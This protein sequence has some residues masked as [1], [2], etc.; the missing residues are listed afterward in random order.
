MRPRTHPNQVRVRRV[1]RAGAASSRPSGGQVGLRLRRSA[2][3][4]APL[5][6]A[7]A[8]VALSLLA[9]GCAEGFGVGLPA[10]E[11]VIRR[12][13]T[14]TILTAQ[15]VP[16]ARL[17]PCIE[18]LKLGWDD[19]T[20]GARDGLTELTF[21]HAN[22]TFLTVRLR[23]SCG[24]DPASE[25]PSG[26][27]GVTRYE[28]VESVGAEIA[29][30][31]IPSSELALIYARSLVDENPNLEING[32]LVVFSVDDE[33]D[34]SLR[35]RTNRAMFGDSFVMIIT[36]V[37]VEERTVDLRLSA[38]SLGLRLSL[39][40]ALDRI[41]EVVPDVTYRGRW[42]FVFEGGCITYDFDATGT[43]AEG[44]AEDAESALGFYDL[45]E[46]RELA[47]REGYQIDPPPET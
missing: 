46:L 42:T 31:L 22:R 32:R 21:G 40:D 9:A 47:R 6:L 16:T 25:V 27:G 29:V 33:I 1:G 15:S 37:D 5:R 10:C 4:A 2:R 34:Q 26:L 13:T 39:D 11:E 30:A 20:F 17:G 36:E 18:E 12:P 3:P 41:E 14:A 19:I 24:F 7:I 35:A 43:V 8:A 23:R 38:D 45:D 44:L 28:D